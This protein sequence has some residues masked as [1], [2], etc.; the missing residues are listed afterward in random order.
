MSKSNNRL[1]T[2]LDDLADL[3]ATV[4]LR[5]ADLLLLNASLKRKL[6][7]I[8]LLEKV[9]NSSALETLRELL[10]ENS[11][12]VRMRVVE[13]LGNLS[14]ESVGRDLIK[15]ARDSDYLVRVTAIEAIG[16]KRPTGSVRCLR[17][18]LN[19]R[20]PLVRA[21]A[22]EGIG[23]IGDKKSIARL[24]SLLNRER[25]SRVKLS[26]CAALYK[27]GAEKSLNSIYQ[28]LD[29]PDY[30]VRCAAAH[31][32]GDLCSRETF[33]EIEHELGTRLEKEKTPAV[34]SSLHSVLADISGERQS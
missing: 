20:N 19:D 34:R 11:P 26:L 28:F 30:R 2:N 32:L 22:A 4:K 8:Q 17:R 18:A 33:C 21:Y 25:Q 1:N 23:E 16:E 27:L 3:P 5:V 24:R 14:H 13:A 31:T 29:T 6:C 9:S 15:A 12:E 7:A 10:T